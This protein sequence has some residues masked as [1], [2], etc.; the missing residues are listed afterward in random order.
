[1]TGLPLGRSELVIKPSL[2]VYYNW[3]VVLFEVHFEC[4][5]MMIL[6]VIINPKSNTYLDI[7]LDSD[8]CKQADFVSPLKNLS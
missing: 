4:C 8:L 7:I 6:I 2:G 5:N 1:M 3:V